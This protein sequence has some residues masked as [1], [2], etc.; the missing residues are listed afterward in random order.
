MDEFHGAFLVQ[1]MSS[2]VKKVVKKRIWGARGSKHELCKK[3]M[4]VSALGI[5]GQWEMTNVSAFG[6]SGPKKV[7]NVSGFGISEP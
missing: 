5:S 2:V 4:N 7:M 3:L 6:A 1:S